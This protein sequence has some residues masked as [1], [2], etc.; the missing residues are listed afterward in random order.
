MDGG[1]AEV[2]GFFQRGFSSGIRTACLRGRLLGSPP[3][4]LA[5]PVAGSSGF[6]QA[7]RPPA[8]SS[9]REQAFPAC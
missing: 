6:L 9:L 5:E 8:F 7:S 2:F 3:P 1:G 4:L